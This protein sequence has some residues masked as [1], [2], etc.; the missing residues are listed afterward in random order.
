MNTTV[1]SL[2]ARRVALAG[3]LTRRAVV[4]LLL[5]GSLTATLLVASVMLL[6]SGLSGLLSDPSL[7]AFFAFAVGA[8]SGY[9]GVK[10]L[11]WL[12]IPD[13]LPE[14]VCVPRGAA[15]SLHRKIRR[16]SKRFGGIRVD[17]VWVTG[18]MNAAVLQRPRWGLVGRMETHLLIGLPLTHS[19]SPL[20]L[21]AILAH[22]FAHLATQRNGSA[23]WARHFRSWW[24]RVVDRFVRDVPCC[25]GWIDHLTEYDVVRGV[26]LSRLEEFEADEIAAR[27]VGADLVGEAL[28]EVALKERF[29]FE[30]YWCKVLEQSSK[31]ARPRF[32]PY[33]EMGHGMVAGFRRPA[34]DSES[35]REL[36]ETHVAGPTALHPSLIERLGALG[37]SPAASRE[38]D[39]DQSAASRHLSPLLPTLSWVFDRQ[40]WVTARSSWRRT[41][42]RARRHS[43]LDKG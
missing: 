28:I 19:V 29:L 32:R 27:L 13:G 43:P 14:G 37:T 11:S 6:H 20:Q 5:L 2:Q 18:D 26:E 3:S 35:L 4:G 12:A 36:C 38:E 21:S 1:S 15:R 17:A 39:T 31:R 8:L 24:F 41:H 22:E 7:H 23:A 40:W 9:V 10:C 33:R 34:A 42:R 25:A 30:D 16:M